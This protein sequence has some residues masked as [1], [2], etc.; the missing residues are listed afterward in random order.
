MAFSD[1]KGIVVT[2]GFKLGAATPIDIRFVADDETDLQSLI[3]NNAVYEGLEVYVK[4]LKQ[5][6]LFNGTAFVDY[7]D[8]V[9]SNILDAEY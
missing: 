7:Y 8:Q 4:S 1:K 2:S 9:V 5:K 6:L 3:D